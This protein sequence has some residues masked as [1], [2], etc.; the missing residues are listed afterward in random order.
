[1]VTLDLHGSPQPEHP[2]QGS[3]TKCT[4]YSEEI[5]VTVLEFADK[6]LHNPT[7]R[8]IEGEFWEC[9]GQQDSMALF[10]CQ[11]ANCLTAA[12]EPLCCVLA[13]VSWLRC[14][15]HF[16]LLKECPL[17]LSGPPSWRRCQPQRA[18]SPL[19]DEPCCE[20][21]VVNLCSWLLWA[22]CLSC[23]SYLFLLAHL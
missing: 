12:T 7:P 1:M 19:Q 2:R 23:F 11:N 20:L 8:A 13:Q 3:V 16:S 4:L 5:V 14:S 6:V 9:I 21:E 15:S 10:F 22:L 17:S 18:L